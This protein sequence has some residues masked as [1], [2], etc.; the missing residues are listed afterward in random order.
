M[1]SVEKIRISQER[2]KWLRNVNVPL[3]ASYI[4]TDKGTFTKDQCIIPNI[5][6]WY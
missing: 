5:F 1:L 3:C 6:L 4:K 2:K